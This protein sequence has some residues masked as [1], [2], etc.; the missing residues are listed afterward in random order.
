[1]NSRRRVN[2]DVGHLILIMGRRTFTLVAGVL[3]ATSPLSAQARKP[4]FGFIPVSLQPSLAAR[5]STFIAQQRDGQWEKVST[6]LGDYYYSLG[7][8]RTRYLPAQKRWMLWRLRNDGMTKFSP[9]RTI[10]STDILNLP[11][12][13]RYYLVV[14]DATYSRNGETVTAP[15]GYL[16]YRD[17]NV[18]FFVPLAVNDLGPGL[19]VPPA[20]PN[21]SLDASGGSVFRIMIGPAMLE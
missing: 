14:G 20:V 15:G 12:A 18:W 17:R 13:R 21:K 3:F 1:M 2:S 11:M 10:W 19:V 16:V 9:R 4:E 5:L 6:F 7:W 8:K